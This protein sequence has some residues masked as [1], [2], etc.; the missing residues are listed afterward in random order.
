LFKDFAN[1]DSINKNEIIAT[2]TLSITA[3][4]A[5]LLLIKTIFLLLFSE[6]FLPAVSMTYI[7]AIG[8]ICHGF[9]DF[10]NRF[11]GAHGKGRQ[12]RNGAIVV[13]VINLAGFF[14]F[15]RMFG[16]TGAAITRFISDI[17]YLLMM[18]YYYKE[19]VHAIKKEHDIKLNRWEIKRS[20]L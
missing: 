19:F 11:L 18:Y 20:I 12:L 10:I 5:F 1:R 8:S 7:V 15:I 17:F 13:G 4:I 6:K 16:V 3:L 14:I 2:I 9:G